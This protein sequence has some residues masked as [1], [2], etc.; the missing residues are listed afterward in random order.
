MITVRSWGV[1]G[2]LVDGGRAGPMWLGK[3]RG[4]AVDLDALALGNR[5]LGNVAAAPAYESSG[6]LTLEFDEATA[7]A[8]TGAIADVAV[9][10]GPAVGWGS[11]AA[12]PA[13]STLRIGRVLDGARVY[14]AVRCPHAAGPSITESM[15]RPAGNGDEKVRALPATGARKWLETSGE[16]DWSS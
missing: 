15:P 2:G 3:S 12:L 6:G 8:I 14:V 11:V 1:A 4:G 16:D 9:T 7:I 5:L 13:G 10:D